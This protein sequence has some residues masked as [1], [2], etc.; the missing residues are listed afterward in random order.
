VEVSGLKVF[1][2][3]GNNGARSKLAAQR[4]AS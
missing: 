3:S 2:K 4:D 1:T